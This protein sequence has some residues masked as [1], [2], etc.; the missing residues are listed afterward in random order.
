M[1]RFAPPLLLGLSLGTLTR[2]ALAATGAD[3][4]LT[5]TELGDGRTRLEAFSL[6]DSFEGRDQWLR[7]GMEVG[8]NDGYAKIDVLLANG[9]I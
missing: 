2:P 3:S 4:T 9:S 7:S 8:V 1:H 6:T 5:F